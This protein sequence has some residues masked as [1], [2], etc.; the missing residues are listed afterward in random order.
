MIE[1]FQVGLCCKIPAR[2]NYPFISADVL[3]R[4]GTSQVMKNT[5]ALP[6]WLSQ[7]V[8]W[9]QRIL[10]KQTLFIKTEMLCGQASVLLK[11]SLLIFHYL[12]K[13][14]ASLCLL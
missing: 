1:H 10:S 6:P 3:S 9:W 8:F 5:A 12:V 7:T 4:K 2:Q 13:C 11:F 14:S